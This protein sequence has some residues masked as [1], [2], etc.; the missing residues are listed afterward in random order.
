MGISSNDR[1]STLIMKKLSLYSI[2]VNPR[3]V[4][5]I[6]E[7]LGPG[8]CLDLGCGSGLYGAALESACGQVL[9]IDIEDRRDVV[10]KNYPFLKC[11]LAKCDLLPTGYK[12]AVAYDII[13]H[14]DDDEGFLR[15]IQKLCS[16]KLLL[17]VPNSDDIMLKRCG[18]T[19]KHHIDKTHR[20]E[21]SDE[22][23]EAL[24]HNVGYKSVVIRPQY[25]RS[26]ISIPL[27]LAKKRR[28][29]KL[30]ARLMM[31]QMRVLRSVGVFQDNII[32]DWLCIAE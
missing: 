13:E 30:M 21:Y 20:R 29:S 31:Y 22:G 16:G 32:S 5:L 26:L 27:L 18:L 11:D 19:H 14:L 24:L 4:A 17:S 1:L 15:N 12:H 9:Q 6:A 10:A 28:F 23:L 2:G 8:G 7:N 3:K 25:N